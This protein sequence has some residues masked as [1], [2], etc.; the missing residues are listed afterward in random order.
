MSQFEPPPPGPVAR[1]APIGAPPAPPVSGAPRMPT[2]V[3]AG[4]PPRPRRTGW[5]VAI[6]LLALAVLVTGGVL[7]LTLIRLDQ[8]LGR[9]ERQDDLIE[10]QRR[11]IDQKETFAA[12]MT[13]LLRTAREFEGV[14]VGGLVPEDRIQSVATRAWLHRWDEAAMRSHIDEARA[15]RDDLVARLDEAAADAAR[16]ASGTVVESVVDRLG[17][18]FVASRLRDDADRFCGRDVWGCVS[19]ADPYVIHFDAPDLRAPY[20]TDFIETGLAY[21]EFAHV[22]QMTNPRATEPALETF[23][24]DVERMADCFALAFLDGWRLHHRVWAG[25]SAYWDVSVGYGYE[26]TASERQVVRDWYAE[27]G[28]R[29]R[30]VLQ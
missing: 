19:S 28:Y 9:I 24:G 25:P 11:L 29:S 8:A 18:G 30:P 2:A 14:P 26:C 10:E 3:M 17:R 4:S 1:P 12:A 22:L 16:N 15:L 23:G 7:V 21:H 5:I 13:E 6:V 27:L 20:V